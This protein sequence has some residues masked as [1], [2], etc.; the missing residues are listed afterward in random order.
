[1]TIFFHEFRA[2]IKSGA[3]AVMFVFIT[4]LSWGVMLG[5]ML[6]D[7]GVSEIDATQLHVWFL[8][9]SLVTSAGIAST[10]FI[11]ERLAGT[12]EV[13]LVSGVTRKELLF[14]KLGFSLVAMCLIGAATLEVA[15]L[16]SSYFS[17]DPVGLPVFYKLFITYLGG[18]LVVSS[19]SA[20]LALTLRNP[21]MTHVINFFVL[22]GLVLLMAYTRREHGVTVLQFFPVY[23]VAMSPFLWLSLKQLRRQSV[24]Q[25][26]LY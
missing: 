26:P 14:G 17:F 7:D 21:R 5:M 2:F 23:V 8:Y 13:L 3:M 1:M 15:Y 25:V 19:S 10:V 18:S 11:R 6:I 9:F 24:V 16:V 4:V 12:L 20:W 22:S